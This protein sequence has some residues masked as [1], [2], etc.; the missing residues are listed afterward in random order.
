MWCLSAYPL[1]S[2]RDVGGCFSSRDILVNYP[3]KGENWS[4]YYSVTQT[5]SCHLLCQYFWNFSSTCNNTVLILV[6]IIMIRS[7]DTL[8]LQLPVSADRKIMCCLSL[9]KESRM[10]GQYLQPVDSLNNDNK[11]VSVCCVHSDQVRRPVLWR[12]SVSAAGILCSRWSIIRAR[13]RAVITPPSSAST[14]TS[15]LNVMML[16]SL[17]P[18]L[19]MF[20]T[21]RGQSCMRT[22]IHTHVYTRIHRHTHTRAHTHVHTHAHSLSHTP[23]TH[24]RTHM[25]T[26]THSHSHTHIHA[27]T[28]THTHTHA[29]THV[30]THTHTHSLTHPTHTHVHTHM[31]TR[32]LTHAHSHTL[33]Y[34]HAHTHTLT[35]TT[36]THTHT[37]MYT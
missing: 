28:H 14:R 33:T 16:L 8:H 35:H 37:H 20:W 30:H 19:K 24:T 7:V 17:K 6:T 1:Q 36:H 11:W 3:F 29:Y 5:K 13:W 23:L 21:A 15:G 18:A 22:H 9:S 32:T 10:N 31:C 26:H 2:I 4:L 34:T 25:H 12:V 27:H